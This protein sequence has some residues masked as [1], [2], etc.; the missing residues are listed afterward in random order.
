[1]SR[2]DIC[3]RQANLI[4]SAYGPNDG[5]G[6]LGSCC[7]EMDVFRS[8]SV[9][10]VLAA[11]PCN[12]S[13]QTQCTGSA[14][15]YSPPAAGNCDTTGCDFNPYRMNRTSFYGP[16][17]TVDTT[18]PFTVVTQFLTDDGT[19]SGTLS[20]IRRYYVQNGVVIPNVASGVTDMPALNSLSTLYCV[21]EAEAFSYADTFDVHGGMGR[22]TTA[23]NTGMVLAVS[24]NDNYSWNLTY[25]DSVF[26]PNSNPKNPGVTRGPCLG[27]NDGPYTVETL[28]PSS[29]FIVSNIRYGDIG[30]TG[31]TGPAT[32]TSSTTTSSSTTSSSTTSSSTISS[33]TTSSS[34]T[35]TYTGSQP[36]QSI[37]GQW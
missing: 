4:W 16:G 28:Y 7:T 35:T 24:I 21:N 9:S 15:G 8:N 27:V 23:L 3:F 34:T 37:W 2:V 20:E 36:T 22:M 11:H 33:S 12:V 5:Y 31:G 6:T 13:A 19:S 14:C 1:M 18:K 32:T 10:T 26:Y 25:L 17:G 29:Q 30:S